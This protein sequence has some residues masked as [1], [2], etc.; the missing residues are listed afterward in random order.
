M[1]RQEYNELLKQ[2][3]EHLF[4]KYFNEPFDYSPYKCIHTDEY[5][6]YP[7]L[8]CC[9]I[10]DIPIVWESDNP[11]VTPENLE[12]LKGF[13]ELIKPRLKETIQTIYVNP[14][15]TITC[16]N[17]NN[18]K[19]NFQMMQKHGNTSFITINDSKIWYNPNDIDL[20][21]EPEIITLARC[22]LWAQMH[23]TIGLAPNKTEPVIEWEHVEFT[24]DTYG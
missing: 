8:N 24:K 17:Y 14:N 10:N 2:L 4:K 9:I 1:T 16:C 5:D 15:D 19:R 18:L 23:K 12:I 20:P 7:K 22:I 3:P 21:N 6:Y 11:W 13:K